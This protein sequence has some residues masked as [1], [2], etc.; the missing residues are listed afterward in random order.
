MIKTKRIYEQYSNNDGV[1]I[2]VDK[3][4]PRGVSKKKAHLSL[5]ISQIAPSKDLRN[6]YSH[7]AEK[8]EDFKERYFRELSEK[9]Y[10][11]E[12][13]KEIGSEKNVTLLYSA[14]D[15]NHNNAAAL[16]EYLTKNTDY[17]YIN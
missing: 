3:L 17:K 13:L 7:D 15:K 6:W 10:Y 9:E 5:W 8:W 2:L 16:K 4:W 14:K 11:V 12:L 1:R